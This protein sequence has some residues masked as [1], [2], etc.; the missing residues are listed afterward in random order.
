MAGLFRYV[1]PFS[2]QQALKEYEGLLIAFRMAYLKVSQT[3]VTYIFTSAV[4]ELLPLTNLPKAACRC[5]T[6][7]HLVRALNFPKN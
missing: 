1:W 2:G 7:D 6:G 5:L 3:L 4:K